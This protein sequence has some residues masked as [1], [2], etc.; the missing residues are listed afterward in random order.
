MV[1]WKN[2][3]IP[4][5]YFK[6]RQLIKD[7]VVELYYIHSADNDSDFFTKAL[8]PGLFDKHRASMVFEIPGIPLE[9]DILLEPG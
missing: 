5:R 4:L 8:P 7:N 2:R 3:H 6:V 9:A 1:A